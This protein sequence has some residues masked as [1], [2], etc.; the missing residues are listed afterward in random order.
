MKSKQLVHQAFLNEWSS[1]FADQKASGLTVREWCEQNKLSIHKYNYWKHQLKEEV[2]SQ[3]VPD[4][5]PLP[6]PIESPQQS[7]APVQNGTLAIQ[8]SDDR[9]IRANRAIRT[10]RNDAASVDLHQWNQRLC[11]GGSPLRLR[12]GTLPCLGMRI[13][14]PSG[15]ST[16]SAAIP[17]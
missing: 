4:I 8:N 17:I 2:F 11:P 14:L 7:I 5:A 10:D 13:R 6:F 1:R 12:K 3:I 9:A 16:S 15:T